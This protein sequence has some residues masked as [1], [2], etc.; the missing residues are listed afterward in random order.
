MGNG[1]GQGG[2]VT[3]YMDGLSGDGSRREHDEPDLTAREVSQTRRDRAEDYAA[4]LDRDEVDYEM[5]EAAN[6]AMRDAREA[7]LDLADELTRE[8]EDMGLYDG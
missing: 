6:E 2:V 7:M 4:W 3:R 1:E 8:A 5:R